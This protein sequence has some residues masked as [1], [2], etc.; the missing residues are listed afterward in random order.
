MKIGKCAMLQMMPTGLFPALLFHL[1][2]GRS[3]SWRIGQ[4]RNINSIVMMICPLVR[5]PWAIWSQAVGAWSVAALQQIKPERTESGSP[6]GGWG[7]RCAGLAMRTGY[8]ID[9]TPLVVPNLALSIGSEYCQL[10]GDWSASSVR[11]R[12]TWNSI[13]NNPNK[14]MATGSTVCCRYE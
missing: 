5:W 3:H 8:P 12:L 14:N 7:P 1:Y 6:T 11:Q 10:L 2:S 9:H 4:P 13:T